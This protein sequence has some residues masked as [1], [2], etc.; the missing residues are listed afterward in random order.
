[1]TSSFG[2]AWLAG[3]TNGVVYGYGIARARISGLAEETACVCVCPACANL[4]NGVA[5]NARKK[6]DRALLPDDGGIKGRRKFRWDD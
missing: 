5:L 3:G 1:M 2:L 4:S 6:M